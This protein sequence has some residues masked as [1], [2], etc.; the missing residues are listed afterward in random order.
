[1][2][3]PPTIGEMTVTKIVAYVAAVEHAHVV[4]YVH[5]V[6]MANVVVYVYA[7]AEADRETAA[8]TTQAQSPPRYSAPAPVATGGDCYDGSPVPAYIITRESGG[9]PNAVNP[10]SGAYGCFQ[11]LPGHFNSGGACAGLSMYSVADQKVCAQRLID[12]SGGTL[13]PWALTR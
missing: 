11:E 12:G 3:V 5:A 1:V 2:S 9:D 10:S 4:D 7:V 8:A 13:A 6:T